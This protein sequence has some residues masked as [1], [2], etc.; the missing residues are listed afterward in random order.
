MKSLFKQILMLS[1]AIILLASIY[2]FSFSTEQTAK[3]KFPKAESAKTE[4]VTNK[5]VK[6]A[7]R[8]IGK[9]TEV[10][11]L[12]M[13]R[14]R[15]TMD[16]WDPAFLNALG[17]ERT[18]IIFN[19]AGVASSTG[20][21]PATIKGA[22]D[23]AAHFTKALGYKKVDILGWSMAGFTAQVMAIEYPQLVRKVV[24][25]GT[26]PGGSPE[27]PAPFRP[28][29]FEIATQPSWDEKGHEFLFFTDSPEGNAAV[30]A[31]LKRINASRNGKLEAPTTK[32]VME[33]QNKAIAAFWFEGQG[34]YF[35][36]LKNLKQPTLIING[37]RDAFFDIKGQWL[38]HR[39]IPNS[40]SQLAIY[41]MAGHGPQHQFPGHVAQTI[42]HFINNS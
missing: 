26:G 33:N 7:Y 22:A 6:Y 32:T 20:E 25:I 29:V 11:I 10:P 35:N 12:M 18:V 40:I 38:L 19:N 16:D 4:F 23:H 5:G 30:K 2:N 27:T 36:Q 41:P 34:D 9:K 42:Q 24:L 1:T 21:V 3:T 17:K 8:K 39:E 37:D 13:T 15:A 28:E 14:F 31:S